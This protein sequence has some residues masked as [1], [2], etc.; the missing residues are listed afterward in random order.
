M[1]GS[2]VY[3]EDK[4][5]QILEAAA[6]F[7]SDKGY[8]STSVQEI[9]EYCGVS[10]GSIYKLFPSK[11][12]LLIE[13]FEYFQNNMFAK[14]ELAYFDESL[15]PKERLIKQI[16]LH[17][18]DFLDKKEFIFIQLKETP[19][20]DKKKLESIT[21]RMKARV[22][23]WEKECLLKAYGEQISPYGWD[24]VLML[25]G[26][27]KEYIHLGYFEINTKERVHKTAIFIIDRVDSMVSDLLRT[28]P[29]P[30]LTEQD[31][32]QFTSQ[33]QLDETV[34]RLDY[35][36]RVLEQVIKKY[37]NEQL[38]KDIHSSFLLLKQELSKEAPQKFLIDALLTYMEKEEQ[39]YSFVQKLRS[40]VL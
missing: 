32:A 33:Q 26:S 36:L 17:I 5:K 6:S 25:H 14:A 22:M 23:L 15:T 3:L 38:K 34:N 30:L 24:L 8:F 1:E 4:K 27:I 31:I 21:A 37:P 35:H 20:N 29:K 18:E 2:A 9:A 16:S 13:V 10:K 40:I 39:L 28:K 11:E 7:F 19:G 12:Q